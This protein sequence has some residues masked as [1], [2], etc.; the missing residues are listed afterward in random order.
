M[1]IEVEVCVL[2]SARFERDVSGS[3]SGKGREPS[4]GS[5]GGRLELELAGF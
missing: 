4:L 1:V 3:G 5:A 2:G